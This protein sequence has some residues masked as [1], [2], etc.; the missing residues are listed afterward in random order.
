MET[1]Y[2]TTIQN[3]IGQSKKV[4]NKCCSQTNIVPSDSFLEKKKDFYFKLFSK[5]NICLKIM[6]RL[7]KENNWVTLVMT[8]LVKNLHGHIQKYKLWIQTDSCRIGSMS[9]AIPKVKRSGL[10]KP[11]EF[12]QLKLIHKVD[13][14][15][16]IM[17][18]KYS[19]DSWY[20]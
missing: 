17:N 13:M 12:E 10:A 1:N 15:A 6:F 16:I 8:L 20:I 2:K 14:Y 7:V 5:I 3:K 11:D 9:R 4:L 19:I 18:L